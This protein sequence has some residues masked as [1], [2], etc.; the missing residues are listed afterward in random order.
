MAVYTFGSNL[1]SQ[2]AHPSDFDDTHIPTLIPFFNDKIVT[3]I[4][5]GAMHTL[6]L[7]DNKVYTYGCNDEAALGRSGEEHEIL[8]VQ[9]KDNVIDISC[10]ASHSVALTDKGT[11]LAWGT[12]RDRTGVI[13]FKPGIKLQK[14][15]KII[16]RNVIKIA[17]CDNYIVMVNKNG[18]IMCYG[19]E[20][21]KKEQRRK[22]SIVSL[23][24][25]VVMR[26]NKN[27]PKVDNIKTGANH[28]FAVSGDKLY[29]WGNN[30]CG[31]M[32]NGDN[33]SFNE[34][35]LIDINNIK[36]CDGAVTHSLFLKI[37]GDLYASGCNTHGNLGNVKVGKE[38]FIPVKVMDNVKMFA[39]SGS[40]NLAVKNNELFSW[41]GNF[42]GELGHEGETH[43][44]P[45]KV[46]FDFGTIIGIHAG[47]NHTIVL[48]KE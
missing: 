4:A 29:G 18:S 11:V 16:A 35:K 19:S 45:K 13:G 34:V 10:G 38:S 7:I 25:R 31:Q 15:P 8:E 40:M 27:M 28:C 3:K 36:D 9:I 6:V 21:F 22:K 42:Y 5:C 26:K 14:K 30:M 12:F 20:L 37:N 23:R 39:C 41:G 33:I 24:T 1:G 47:C 48:T 17:S 2:L 46:N 43:K 32:G 44:E